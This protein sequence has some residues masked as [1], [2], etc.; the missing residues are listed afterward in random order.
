M[1]KI[2]SLL[3]ALLPITEE[4]AITEIEYLP[5]DMVPENPLRKYS[6]VDVRCHDKKGRR[7]KCYDSAI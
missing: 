1:V 5:V 4:D 7:C 6:I 2:I 3:N